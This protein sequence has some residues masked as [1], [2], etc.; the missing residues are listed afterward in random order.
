MPVLL[1][2]IRDAIK[3][4]ETKGITRYR[5]AKETDVSQAALSKFVNGER[6]LG[7]ESIE[8][9]AGFLGLEIAVRPRTKQKGR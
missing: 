5:I 1:D 9:L 2:A 3:R 4:A 8:K 7:V 6:G